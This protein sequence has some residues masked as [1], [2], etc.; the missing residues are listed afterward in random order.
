MK[1]L[2]FIFFCVLSL[3]SHAATLTG[4]D[5]QLRDSIFQVYRAMPEDSTRAMFM[6]G[7]FHQYV[8][9]EWA[10]EWLDTAFAF[11]IKTKDRKREV[12]LLYEYFYY[13]AFRSDMENM[14]KTFV[15]LKEAAFRYKLYDDYYL[16]WHYILQ[17]K[18]AS[19]NTEYVILEAQ[20]M[21]K[22][23]AR[24]KS[25]RGMF[26]SYV[27]EA[28]AFDFAKN[29]SKAVDV[30][31]EALEQP[32]VSLGDQ[33]MVR[34]HLSMTYYAIDQLENSL[35]ELRAQRELINE[36]T[37]KDP[38]KLAAYKG[39]LF[40]AEVEFCKVYMDLRD[41]PNLKM[42]LDE[43]AKYYSDDCF[44]SYLIYYHFCKAIYYQLIKDWDRC[45]EQ[46]NIALSAFNGTQPMF[47][48]AIHH[49]LGTN[50]MAAGRYKEA[51]EVCRAVV[52]ESDSINKSVLRMNKEAV[53]ANYEI[54]K[55]LFDKEY[56]E[57]LFWQ[58]VVAGSFLCLVLLLYGVFRLYQ[59]KRALKKSAEEMRESY[60][61][62]RAADK[63]KESFLRNIVYEIRL[64]L[65]AV[66]GFSDYLCQEKDL[67]VEAQQ[68]YS[69]IIKRN[70]ETLI[71]LIFNVLDLSRL[72]SGMMKFNMQEYDAVQLCREV[73][74]MVEMRDGNPVHLDFHTDLDI[75]PIQ[76]DTARF[77]KLMGSLLSAPQD[78]T[79]PCQVT[80][81]LQRAGNKL[82]IKVEGSPILWKVEGGGGNQLQHDINRL[83]LETFNGTYQLLEKNVGKTM[84]IITYPIKLS[85]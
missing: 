10:T 64:P 65:N 25:P 58:I 11:T 61:T 4:A 73:Q 50:Y 42:H 47:K 6:R 67:S 21:C 34:R 1:I 32:G 16:S 28:S 82:I 56:K 15:P 24:L 79:E 70:A 74:I 19:G 17:T 40:S 44:R 77:M 48:L 2:C 12:G 39:M 5:R 69:A 75:L 27:S 83:Y 78:Y 49:L 7:M 71:D 51:A 22:E 85:K 54:R 38:E 59:I 29:F 3:V 45:F 23:A 63:M 18:A 84:I 60:A 41:I 33:L 72:E 76:V 26:L 68:E 66:V 37:K 46:F 30:Y 52:L 8:G 13:Y 35:R 53:Q 57:K 80:Y 20:K 43:A 31:L 36:I 55:A 9:Q 81:S 62:V 14:E